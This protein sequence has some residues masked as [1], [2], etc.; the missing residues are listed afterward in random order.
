MYMLVDIFWKWN[1]HELVRSLL[2]NFTRPYADGCGRQPSNAAQVSQT[3]L[4]F[5]KAVLF[6]FW[7]AARVE[8]TQT[9]SRAERNMTII[10]KTK[11]YMRKM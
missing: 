10:L 7:A 1:Q 8:N 11:C 9:R 4:M 2:V 5:V 3:M 6:T